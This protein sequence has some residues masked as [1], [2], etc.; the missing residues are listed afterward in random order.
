MARK[1]NIELLSTY[2]GKIDYSRRWRQ[3]E[4]YDQLWQRLIN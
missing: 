4:N 2:R 3:N 1:S